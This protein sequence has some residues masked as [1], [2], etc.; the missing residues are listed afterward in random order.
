MIMIYFASFS[1]NLFG[2]MVF[3]FIFWKKMKEDF[4]SNII[5]RS[6]TYIFLGVSIFYLVSFNFYYDWFLWMSFIGGVLGLILA[7]ISQKIK[8]FEALEAFVISSLPWLSLMFLTD[9][10]IKSSLTSFLAFAVVLILVFISYWLDTNY[11]SFSWYKSG[12]IGLTGLIILLAIFTIRFLVA[13]Y[14]IAV[15]SF[16]GRSELWMSGF[17]IIV[18]LRLIFYL[19]KNER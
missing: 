19:T 17:F 14:E 3:L 16:V 6:S 10:I 5:F 4:G 1:V 12:K 2:L 7:V 18:S 13:F 15:L 11:K 9:S 8:F